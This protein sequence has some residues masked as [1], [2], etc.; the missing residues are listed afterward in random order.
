VRRPAV[1]RHPQRRGAG[2]GG[3]RRLPDPHAGVLE[4]LLGDLRPARLPAGWLVLRRQGPAEPGVGGLAWLGH[5]ALR[6]PECDQYR[7]LARLRGARRTRPC[8]K[9][10]AR[11]HPSR[12]ESG[13]PPAPRAIRSRGAS[14]VDTTTEIRPCN[15]AISWPSAASAWAAW[16]RS[17]ERRV[18]KVGRS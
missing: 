9:S 1:L 17:E 14:A 2:T 10:F 7:A 12:R 5:R 3:G 15:D 13:F 6:R 18:G 11:A 4:R 16:R 8:R